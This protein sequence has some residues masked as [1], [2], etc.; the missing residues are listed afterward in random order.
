[1]GGQWLRLKACAVTSLQLRNAQSG[2]FLALENRQY[3]L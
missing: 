3:L 2:P 1:M